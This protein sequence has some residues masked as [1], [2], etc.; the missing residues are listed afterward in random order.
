MVASRSACLRT[1]SGVR[2]RSVLGILF[3][4]IGLAK[5]LF[6][7]DP[8]RVIPPRNNA[9]PLGVAVLV[10]STVRPRLLSLLARQV[11][12]RLI[13]VSDWLLEGRKG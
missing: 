11:Y 8:W 10:L 9:L 5:F 7:L 4:A 1:A 2:S 3:L 13:L 6:A 12:L